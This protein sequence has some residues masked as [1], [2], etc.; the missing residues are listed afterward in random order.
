MEEQ[1]KCPKC[2]STQLSANKKGFSGGKAAAGAIAVGGIGLLA[3]T[4]GSGKVEITCLKC[5]YKYKA[6]DYN[7][8]V[9]KLNKPSDSEIINKNPLQFSI[10]FI[11]L[12]LA[13]II[14]ICGG[15][16]WFLLIMPMIGFVSIIAIESFKT[17][18]KKKK[19]IVSKS[20]N[21]QEIDAKIKEYIR[22]GQFLCAIEYCKEQTGA[23]DDEAKN[24]VDLIASKY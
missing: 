1:L 14:P 17:Q 22:T 7:K 20:V 19:S 16:W 6:G 15:S 5:G 23:T 10:I 9:N 13:F 12:F 11:S 21:K 4:I 18:K 8:E 2:G 3:G 24:Y